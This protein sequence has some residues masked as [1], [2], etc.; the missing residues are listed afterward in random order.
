MAKKLIVNADDFGRSAGVN[1]G[2]IEA[3]RRGIV[4]STSLMVN[5]PAAEEAFALAEGCPDLGVG[6][7]LVFTAGRPILPPERVPTLVDGEGNFLARDLWLLRIEEVDLAQ[8]KAELRAQIERFMERRGRPTHLD[9]H[10]FVHV[11]PPFFALIVELAA[12]YGLPMRVPFGR[13]W[14]AM[15][16]QDAGRFGLSSEQAREMVRRDIKLVRSSGVPHPDHFVAEF[17]GQGNI[18]VENLL[19]ILARLEDGITELMTHPGYADQELRRFSRYVEE[20]ERELASLTD[21][22]VREAI[23]ELGIELVNYEEVLK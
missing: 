22:R 21:P 10:H 17:F 13:N 2:V 14:E 3:H 1:R 7:H 11:Y 4:T 19:D 8:L 20:R 15:A 6:V 5:M 12:E 16:A 18:E 23:E 9:C